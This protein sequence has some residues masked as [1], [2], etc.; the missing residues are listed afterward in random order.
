M[1]NEKRNI[2]FAGIIVII[3][4]LFMFYANSKTF[5]KIE[6][7]PPFD[8]VVKL[9]TVADRLVVVSMTNEMHIRDWNYITE[10]PLKILNQADKVALM[11]D[12]RLIRILSAESDAVEIECLDKE[13]DLLTI[14]LGYGIR[15]NILGVNQTGNIAGLVNVDM[16]DKNSNNSYSKFS[17]AVIASNQ[18]SEITTIENGNNAIEL[19]GISVSDNGRY[20]AV[21]GRKNN[22]GWIGGVD[23]NEKK[24]LWERNSDLSDRFN[25]AAFSPDSRIVYVGGT[26]RSI[27]GF[28]VA[29]GNLVTNWQMAETIKANKK[30][31][32]PAIA[33]SN[34]GR[35]VAAATEPAG[36][37]YL[38]NT[39][40]NESVKHLPVGHIL[41]SGIAFSPDDRYIA[42]GGVLMK[43]KIKICKVSRAR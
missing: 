9:A 38:W 34:D 24:L 27:I 1:S 21:V 8:G 29:T 41:I 22:L 3:P 36:A 17:I 43:N 2:I 39:Q 10:K 31:Y 37:I 30:Q 28:D 23:I 14:P 20:I 12:N 35:L 19:F 7:N 16:F 32:T 26:G 33:V 18:L 15:C 13:C 4:A 11:A 5:I 40:G 42:A 25:C 6:L